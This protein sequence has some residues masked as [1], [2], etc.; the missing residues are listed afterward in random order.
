MERVVAPASPMREEERPPPRR[1]LVSRVP[2]TLAD[3]HRAD[4]HLVV[5]PKDRR[6]Q[7]ISRCLRVRV[8]R[9]PGPGEINPP[10]VDR[11][12]T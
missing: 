12:K 6:A 2:K 8:N 5:R 7:L 9:R 3:L 11:I 1:V 4:R 10:A